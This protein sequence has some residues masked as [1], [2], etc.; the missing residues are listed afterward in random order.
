MKNFN[1]VTDKY[2]D[3]TLGIAPDFLPAPQV[4]QM[5]AV[6]MNPEVKEY[7]MAKMRKPAMDEPQ[8]DLP[9]KEISPMEQF[10][11]E[12]YQEALSQMKARQSGLG[13]SQMAAGV[14]DALARKDSS[15]T[16]N[17]FKDLRSN[18]E[19]QTVGEFSKQKANALADFKTKKQ[20][21]SL[22]PNSPES[23]SF[24]KLIQATMPNIAKSY[25]D[26]FQLITAADKENVLDFGKMREQID[27]RK[28]EA[29]MK[30][31]MLTQTRM[32]RND[33]R[34]SKAQEL[35]STRAKQM[36]LY[37]NGVA[38]EEQF[39]QATKDS[40]SYDP[41]SSGQ[42][43]D[44][45]DWAPNILKNNKAIESQASRDA[46]VESFLRDASGAA[47]SE[48]ERGAYKKLYFPLPGDTSQVVENKKSLRN[49][50]MRSAAAS[51]G[52][53]HDSADIPETPMRNSGPDSKIDAFMKRNGI[54]DRTEAV[55]IL[56]EN[57]KI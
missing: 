21:N 52:L 19:N 42:F 36:G 48:K 9:P 28:A 3:D 26:S 11:P 16:D 22:D 17:Y 5:P 25:G 18:I 2:E 34:N 51:A 27:A 40:S 31:D 8:I 47:I 55:R 29:Q 1:Y 56:K 44:N 35:S 4:P 46:W 37:K 49:E 50:K 38:A 39:L 12:K 13:L 14:G 23:Q 41:T 53:S 45:S 54:S 6:E 57:G 43:I 7:L 20:L 24:R 30:A 15:G 33:A 32:D 10:S